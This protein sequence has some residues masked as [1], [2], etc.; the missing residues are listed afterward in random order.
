LTA[1]VSFRRR[2]FLFFSGWYTIWFF[3]GLLFLTFGWQP[4]FNHWEDFLFLALAG[5]VLLLA[6]MPWLGTARTWI[7]FVWVALVSG[8][9]EALGATTGIPF[10][11]YHYTAGMGP[12]LGGVLPLAIPFAWWVVL[13]PL[14]IYAQLRAGGRRPWLLPVL[15]GFFAMLID[16]ALEP[17]ATQLRGYWVWEQ[18]GPWYGV[19]WQNFLGWWLTATVISAG[20]VPLI[21]KP[22]P[23]SAASWM[24]QRIAFLLLVSVLASFW[25]AAL[26]NAMWP[27]LGALTLVT[28][29]AAYPLFSP[30]AG[31]R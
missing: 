6:V 18:S 20:L 9:I 11:H 21:G 24:A 12:R 19:P 1:G 17:V 31:S 27:A 23:G 3:V 25:A 30:P 26:A 22:R 15:V 16:L 10:G 29:A 13:L 14:Q 7:A 2:C 5:I 4:L 28:L 8:G